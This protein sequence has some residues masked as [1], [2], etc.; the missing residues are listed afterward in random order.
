MPSS[1]LYLNQNTCTLQHLTSLILNCSRIQCRDYT[2]HKTVTDTTAARGQRHTH[3]PPKTQSWVYSRLEKKQTA[4]HVQNV[5]FSYSYFHMLK[6]QAY[7]I[8][9][10]GR[11]KQVCIYQTL[12]QFLELCRF[13]YINKQS[14]CSLLSS[15]KQENIAYVQFSSPCHNRDENQNL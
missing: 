1:D 3:A 5:F 4:K 12:H 13:P 2:K 14:N 15:S 9:P 8:H 7:K 10:N 6:F 11:S